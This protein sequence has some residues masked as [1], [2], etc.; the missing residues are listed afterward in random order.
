M[1]HNKHG[2]HETNERP[3]PKRREGLEAIAIQLAKTMIDKGST[4]RVAAFSCFFSEP[5]VT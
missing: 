3:C 1:L 5:D 4:V 2:L